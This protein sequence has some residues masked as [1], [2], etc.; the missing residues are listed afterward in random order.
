M[1]RYWIIIVLCI[2]SFA[3]IAALVFVPPFRLS[4]GFNV[5][6]RW[7]IVYADPLAAPVRGLPAAMHP[8]LQ[9]PLMYKLR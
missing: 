8:V 3:C 9:S 6:V 1:N 2:L 4:G 7:N 5:N